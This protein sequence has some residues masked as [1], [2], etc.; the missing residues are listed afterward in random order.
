MTRK[1]WGRGSASRTDYVLIGDL[2]GA[3]RYRAYIPEVSS[4]HRLVTARIQP[5]SMAKSASRIRRGPETDEEG[6]RGQ[7]EVLKKEGSIEEW[8]SGTGR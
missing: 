1:A 2:L 6:L 8:K 3:A 7:L 5:A 4:D